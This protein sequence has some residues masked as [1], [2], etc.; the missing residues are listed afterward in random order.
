M[1]VSLKNKKKKRRKESKA[2]DAPCGA[3]RDG[4]A[5][6]L[7]LI[8]EHVVLAL[9]PQRFHGTSANM[10]LFTVQFDIIWFVSVLWNCGKTCDLIPVSSLIN[11]SISPCYCSWRGTCVARLDQ[12][13]SSIKFKLQREQFNGD[14]FKIWSSVIMGKERS[15]ESCCDFSFFN[16]SCL[17]MRRNRR[18]QPKV[19]VV[20]FFFF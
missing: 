8:D 6:V 16:S 3:S 1:A 7:S 13:N 9:S 2:N 14:R 19:I 10:L 12:M 11:S 18:I 17:R 4:F 15:S 5:I 20:G